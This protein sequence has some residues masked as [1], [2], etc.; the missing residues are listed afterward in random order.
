MK[1]PS[2]AMLPKGPRGPP[3]DSHRTTLDLQMDNP[4]EQAQR[5]AQS[6]KHN[7]QHVGPRGADMIGKGRLTT[8]IARSGKTEACELKTF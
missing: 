7:T 4:F 1:S 3:W 5:N 6:E 8:Q 2:A